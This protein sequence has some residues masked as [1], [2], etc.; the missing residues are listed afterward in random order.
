MAT[1]NT[2]E[3]KSRRMV[4]DMEMVTA[5]IT[6]FLTGGY[7]GAISPYLNVFFI[8]LGLSTKHAG[9]ISGIS[10]AVGSCFNPVWISIADASRQRKVCFFVSLFWLFGCLVVW[11]F[12]CLGCWVVS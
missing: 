7:F 5:K 8:S 6:Y 9:L 1:T 10:L 3:K 2:S 4:V 12:G 11:L